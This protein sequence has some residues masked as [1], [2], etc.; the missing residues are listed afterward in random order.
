VLTIN[1]AHSD[2]INDLCWSNLG[3]YMV[4]AGNDCVLK[5]WNAKTGKECSLMQ[6]HQASVS[7]CGFRYGCV[8]STCVDGCVKVW[9][10]KGHEITTLKG[11]QGKV[12]ACDLYFKTKKKLTKSEPES[13]VNDDESLW[14]DK[15][16]EA[17]N[18]KWR[19]SHKERLQNRKK[20]DDDVEVEEILLATVSEDGTLRIWRPVESESLNSLEGHNGKVNSVVIDETGLLA[21]ASADKSVNVWNVKEFM[22]KIESGHLVQDEVANNK[23]GHVSEVTTVYVSKLFIFSGSVDGM[24]ITWRRKDVDGRLAG[25]QFTNKLRAHDFAVRKICLLEETFDHTLIASCGEHNQRKCI[26]LWKVDNR[27]SNLRGY[28]T[29]FA[30]ETVF[31]MCLH[32][33]N[34]KSY[35]VSVEAGVTKLLVRVYELVDEKSLSCHS[36]L[37]GCVSMLNSLVS[38]VSS[39]SSHLYIS[40]VENKIL[41]LSFDSLITQF[42]TYVNHEHKTPSQVPRLKAIDAGSGSDMVWF[43]VVTTVG[44]DI[45]LAGSWKGDVYAKNEDCDVLLLLKNC[46][47]KVITEI[48]GFAEDRVLT[49]SLDGTVKVWS[50]RCERQLGQFNLTSGVSAVCQV[51]HFSNALISSNSATF[52]V[53]DQMG[54]LKIIRWHDRD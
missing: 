38:R 22:N 47:K 17:D 46:H 7:S 28:T 33:K 6:G 48:I 11:H 34:D 4:S 43:N 26:R 19:E 44:S 32:K 31:Y 23:C 35:L 42:K 5:V 40:L 16:D 12:N 36:K 2:W 30:S 49:A 14:A 37:G 21:T 39:S 54:R 3:D 51:T 52:I 1:A 9:S 27:T 25:L 8:V 20:G 24:L 13:F 10:Q 50:G 53:G 18:V 15:V 45:V 29:V 41:M